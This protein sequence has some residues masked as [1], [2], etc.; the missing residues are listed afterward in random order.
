V[1]A[2]MLGNAELAL[3]DLP[4]AAPAQASIAQVS[5]AARRAADLTRQLSPM[6]GKATW[7]LSRST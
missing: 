3:L 7:L 5:T 4:P 1:L 2:A 6:R